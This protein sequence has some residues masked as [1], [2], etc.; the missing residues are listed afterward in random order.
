[1]NRL[2]IIDSSRITAMSVRN[3]LYLKAPRVQVFE[4][5]SEKDA[6]TI[7]L[8]INPD[9]ILLDFN[10]PMIHAAS[11]AEALRKYPH[12]ESVP[13]V[14][15]SHVR[16]LREEALAMCKQCDD[17]LQKPISST[18]LFSVLAQFSVMA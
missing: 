2:L 5:S 17:W 14:G 6:I 3:S 18:A 15:I 4:A 9:L 8:E 11:M 7:A 1:M 10:S 12:L 16:Q 13:I